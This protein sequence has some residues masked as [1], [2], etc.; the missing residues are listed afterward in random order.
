MTILGSY[1]STLKRTFNWKEKATRK[2][3]WI[4][5]FVSFIIQITFVYLFT[6]YIPKILANQP[7]KNDIL[8]IDIVFLTFILYLFVTFLT[9][10]SLAARR[11]NDLNKSKFFTL[12]MF[13]PFIGLLFYFG[14]LGFAKSVTI[15]ETK[16][17]NQDNN[18]KE[19]DI[20]EVK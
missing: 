9:T 15:E 8:M 19:I 1:L 3:F 5:H 18:K 7:T 14:Y 10:I 2:D 4:F 11:L 17:L 16:E 12:I 20:I 6:A 13:V